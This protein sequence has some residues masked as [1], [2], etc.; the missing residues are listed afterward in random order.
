MHRPIFFQDLT[1]EHAAQVTRTLAHHSAQTFLGAQ[2]Y[3]AWRDIPSVYVF[4]TQ[5][6]AISVQD[7]RDMVNAARR[8]GA[9]AVETVTLEASHSPFLSMP[10]R[11]VDVCVKAAE[12]SALRK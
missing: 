2:G 3:A 10:G 8:A 9:R 5:D 7:Q 12:E 11:V 6:R 4:C 1:P